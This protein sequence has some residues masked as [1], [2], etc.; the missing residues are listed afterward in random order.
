MPCNDPQEGQ[1]TRKWSPTDHRV[2]PEYI[3][4]SYYNHP[5]LLSTSLPPPRYQKYLR[6]A[7]KQDLFGRV[8]QLRVLKKGELPL[9][10]KDIGTCGGMPSTSSHV[11]HVG[12]PHH[13]PVETLVLRPNDPEHPSML[14]MV[15]TSR[16]T[17][18]AAYATT[19]KGSETL[20][21][22]VHRN[23]GEMEEIARV[24]WDAPIGEAVSRSLPGDGLR[25][26]QIR[27]K[28]GTMISHGG[29]TTAIDD[30]MRKAK[31]W[32]PSE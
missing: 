11:A 12:R 3:L 6:P 26:V 21:W 1:K 32:F 28:R 27:S 7:T 5:L 15:F 2:L 8:W 23:T 10:F 13:L 9:E 17:R 22:R 19:T 24:A 16:R 20:V 30:F 18:R 25:S 31:G 4:D 29:R 14:D